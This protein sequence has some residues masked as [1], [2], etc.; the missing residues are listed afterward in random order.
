MQEL[1][2]KQPGSLIAALNVALQAKTYESQQQGIHN[3]LKEV[4]RLP[5]TKTKVRMVGLLSSKLSTAVPDPDV[6][7]FEFPEGNEVEGWLSS[8]FLEEELLELSQN[9]PNTTEGT[10]KN[11]PPGTVLGL[12]SRGASVQKKFQACDW[13]VALKE[14]YKHGGGY[15]NWCGKQPKINGI[16]QPFGGCVKKQA[17]VS[18]H[19]PAMCNDGGLDAA[20]FRHDSGG[21]SEDLW[22]I[23]T[24][25]L[26]KVDGDFHKALNGLSV[27][28]SFVDGFMRSEGRTLQAAKCLFNYLPCLRYETQA[29]WKWCPSRWGGSPC[30]ETRT[31]YFTY[32]PVKDFPPG[33]YSR[34]KED[35]CGPAG[36]Y[37]NFKPKAER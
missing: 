18:E 16:A 1:Q 19:L 7:A 5:D 4:Y 3:Y 33:D 9:V 30:K 37:Q 11:A 36:C 29:Y 32:F 26:C 20:C 22:G 35:A 25:S 28:S 17:R 8:L 2:G 34:F 21:F 15:G 27:S 13:Q 23:A 31:A 14:F 12:V 24:K 6:Q 10:T